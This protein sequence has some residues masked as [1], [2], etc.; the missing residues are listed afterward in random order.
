LSW[1][2]AFP[3]PSMKILLA[4]DDHDSRE[5]LA[6][7][8]EQDTHE[9]ST[10]ENGLDAWQLFERE[11]FSLMISDWRMPEM[12]GLTLCR[13][14][15]EL[16]RPQYTYIIL[17]TALKGK[18]NYL[19]AMKAGVDDFISKPYDPDELK[20]RVM[21]AERILRLQEHVQ[22]L[23]GILPT[24]MYC[25]NIRDQDVWVG[26]EQYITQ[27]SEAMFSHGICP[28]CY[29]QIVEPELRRTRSTGEG[30]P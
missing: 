14:I 13:K 17:I 29:S 5:M 20:A 3:Q 25:K 23:E 24:C 6:I 1:W 15:R 2:Y 16:H 10:A 19:E 27:H 28:S 26:I 30:N 4:E 7:L 12:D 8:L 18:T 22:R 11:Q 21:V 9:V